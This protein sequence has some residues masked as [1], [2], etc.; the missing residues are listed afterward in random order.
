[1]SFPCD[2]TLGG[3]GGVGG[4]GGGG[5]VAILTVL[6]EYPRAS[7]QYHLVILWRWSGS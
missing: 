6:I 7:I 2:H 5:M 4:G 3:V 1:M